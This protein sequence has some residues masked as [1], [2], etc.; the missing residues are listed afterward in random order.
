MDPELLPMLQVAREIDLELRHQIYIDQHC[1]LVQQ[2]S[3]E[4]PIDSIVSPD[5]RA[6]M[7]QVL[8]WDSV[9]LL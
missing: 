7:Q 9:L 2:L 1:E 3:L 5:W 4:N 6:H 8:Q